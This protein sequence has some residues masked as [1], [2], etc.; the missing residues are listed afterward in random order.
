MTLNSYEAEGDGYP[1]YH[2]KG[3]S[4]IVAMAATGGV[5]ALAAEHGLKNQREAAVKDHDGVARPFEGAPKDSFAHVVI[6]ATPGAGLHE[7][8]MFDKK[9]TKAMGDGTLATHGTLKKKD[10]SGSV[11]GGEASPSSPS[12][13]GMFSGIRKLTKK[14]DRSVSKGH[15]RSVSTGDAPPVPAHGDSL[16]SNSADSSPTN[17]NEEKREKNV[18]HKDPPAGHGAHAATEKDETSPLSAPTDTTGSVSNQ[19]AGSTT[20]AFNNSYSP[21]SPPTSPSKVGF[22]EKVKGEFMVVQGSLTRDKDL[23]E[24]GQ[25]MKKGTM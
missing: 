19:N 11:S 4:G 15:G 16:D 7:Q 13:S 2:K 22:R 17:A 23:K 18:L 20:S 21:S 9:A 25:K 6:P 8:E 5:G 24:A 1:E 12:K 14:R 3:V 10:R